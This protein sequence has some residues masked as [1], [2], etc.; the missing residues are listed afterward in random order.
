MNRWILAATLLSVCGC[1]VQ[2]EDTA[3]TYTATV[4]ENSED[5]VVLEISPDESQNRTD[6][7]TDQPAGCS[8]ITLTD[9]DRVLILDDDQTI[10]FQDLEKSEPVTVTFDRNTTVIHTEESRSDIQ[11]QKEQNPSQK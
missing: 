10:G 9:H 3:C 2:A 6:D 11:E 7:R 8:R 5:E 1:S 4:V